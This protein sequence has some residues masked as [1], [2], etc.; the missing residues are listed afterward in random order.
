MD[1]GL[2]HAASSFTAIGLWIN[3]SN[4]SVVAGN[5]ISSVSE[6]TD[7]TG[8]LVDGSSLIEVRNNTV[9]R[10]EDATNNRGIVLHSATDVT[11]IGNRILN[12]ADAPGTFG[13]ADNSSS[14]GIN[15]IDNFIAGYTTAI[16][17]TG[18]VACDF[19]AGNISP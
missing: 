10:T 12:S 5:V 19:Q 14:S 7:S 15:C 11:I 8:I 17:S 9:L 13:I 1:T 16:E 6:T 3:E 18:H 2:G 4:D